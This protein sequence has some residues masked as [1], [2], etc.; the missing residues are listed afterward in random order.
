M[1]CLLLAAVAVGVTPAFARFI[2]PM[3]EG[4]PVAKLVE[5]LEKIA[6]AEPKSAEALLNLGRAHGMAY[7]QKIDELPVWKGREKEGAWP[8]FTPRFVP[9]GEVKVA[10][11]AEKKAAA[12]AH[13]DSAL[14]AYAR[15][16]DLDKDSLVIRLGIAW[17]T[18]QG[19]KKDEAVKLYRA[20]AADAWEKKEKDLKALGLGGQTLTAEIAGYLTPLLDAEKDKDEIATLKERVATL[21]K[22]PYPITPI[23]VPLADGLTAA[24]LEAPAARVKFD[25]SGDGLGR[26]WNWITPKAAWLVYDPKGDGK[27]ASGRQL[28][29]N[30]TFWMF[31]SNGYGPLAALD[32]DR[33]G[34]LSGKELAGLALWHDAN[35][36]GVADPG[37][38][39]SLAE[40]GIV[41]ISC[42][43]EV[44]KGH[45]DKIAF[46]PTGV[47]FKDGTTRPTF[48]LVLK[49]K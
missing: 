49:A 45:A 16:L 26:E 44:L 18:E 43:W 39:K 41:A 24:D 32:D 8:G 27:I 38:V 15:A 31:W 47:T 48:D 28:F 11:D 34:K 3:L 4:V 10:A 6:T 20:V 12:Q 21:K 7:A 30:V 2:R 14:K 22:L 42:K 33:D 46:S 36:N 1:R 35:G 19:G 25:A 29:G 13:L 9:F 37:E 40:Y 17:L 23:A 5:N